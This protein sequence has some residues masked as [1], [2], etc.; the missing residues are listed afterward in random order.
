MSCCVNRERSSESV[1]GREKRNRTND[2]GPGRT[3]DCYP[4][5]VEQEDV[6]KHAAGSGQVSG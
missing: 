4:L 6:L 5:R 2:H 1:L 3:G